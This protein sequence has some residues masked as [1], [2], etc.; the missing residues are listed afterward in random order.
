MPKYKLA[1]KDGSIIDVEGRRFA[2]YVGNVQYWFIV[3]PS[4]QGHGYSISEKSTGFG[5]A[6]V[7]HSTLA[8]CAGNEVEA[9]KRTVHLT[10]SRAGADRFKQAI[11]KA[12]AQLAELRAAKQS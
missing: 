5:V 9:A 6:D 12:E 7:P 3:H 2:F 1:G 4:L 11:K 8:A 10:V